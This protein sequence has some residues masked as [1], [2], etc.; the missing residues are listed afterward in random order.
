MVTTG[1][2]H[3]DITTNEQDSL[4]QFFPVVL[5]GVAILRVTASPAAARVA[6]LLLVP[7]AAVVPVFFSAVPQTDT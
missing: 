5:I 1:A 4:A 2:P 6:V 3:L 7:T